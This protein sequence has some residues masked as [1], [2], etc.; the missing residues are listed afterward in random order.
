MPWSSQ[1]L[2]LG[3][4][5]PVRCARSAFYNVAI[6]RAKFDRFQGGLAGPE[7]LRFKE[8][9][10]T[11]SGAERTIAPFVEGQCSRSLIAGMC[12]QDGILAVRAHFEEDMGPGTSFAL[13]F[14]RL[15]STRNRSTP[16]NQC[17]LMEMRNARPRC[18]PHRHGQ[19]GQLARKVC[20]LYALPSGGEHRM[21]VRRAALRP[22]EKALP[23]AGD[24]KS[25]MR[26]TLF[27]PPIADANMAGRGVS[28]TVLVRDD[29]Q[30]HVPFFGYR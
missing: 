16:G 12:N 14:E 29:N 23:P 7:K 22:E 11:E 13:A 20:R 4:M 2:T 3:V 9:L 26:P 8:V 24:G 18:H 5:R 27:D 15:T 10:E 30:R 1:V 6:P 28:N 21:N 19:D 25:F 17:A